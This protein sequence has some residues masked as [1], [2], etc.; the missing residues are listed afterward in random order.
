VCIDVYEIQGS[1][2]GGNHVM[3]FLVS[4]Q[5]GTRVTEEHTAFYLE[6]TYSALLQCVCNPPFRL[7]STIN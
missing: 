4:L 7:H 2:S 6:D 3:V 1:H 5:G